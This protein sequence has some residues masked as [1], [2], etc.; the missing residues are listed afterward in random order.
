MEQ[1]TYSDRNITNRGNNTHIGI[2]QDFQ[3]RFKILENLQNQEKCIF[4]KKLFFSLH[5]HI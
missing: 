2:Y 4:I 3:I 1:N 5:S